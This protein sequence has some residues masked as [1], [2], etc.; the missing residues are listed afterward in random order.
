MPGAARSGTAWC[1]MQCAG[2]WQKARARASRREWSCVW[3]W[4]CERRVASAGQPWGASTGQTHMAQANLRCACVCVRAG[5]YARI[6]RGVR[7]EG[8]E[9][10]RPRVARRVRVRVPEGEGARR[11][12]TRLAP[13]I[14]EA[15]KKSQG[16]LHI[17]PYT[18]RLRPPQ[19]LSVSLADGENTTKGRPK[20]NTEGTHARV[21]H[22]DEI[23]R[24]THLPNISRWHSLFVADL[25][26]LE[27]R[28]WQVAAHRSAASPGSRL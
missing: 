26:R 10:G 12:L 28:D 16:S 14:N 21:H 19:Q 8:H 18:E 23:G 2:A 24:Y 11:Q 20:R 6:S 27:P 25:Q 9:S 22:R 15:Y 13:R 3:L 1:L 4:W 17:K 5:T 7:G